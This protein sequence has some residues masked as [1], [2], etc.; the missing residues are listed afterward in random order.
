LGAVQRED[1]GRRGVAESAA[2]EHGGDSKMR[3]GTAA[4]PEESESNVLFKQRKMVA[5]RVI[6]LDRSSGCQGH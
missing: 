3:A 6:V 1:G 5:G 4:I 2:V